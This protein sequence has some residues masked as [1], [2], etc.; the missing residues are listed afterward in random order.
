[1]VPS[2]QIHPFSN[3]NTPHASAT[4]T[5]TL[6]YPHAPPLALALHGR[7]RHG[8]SGTTVEVWTRSG[9]AV[10]RG[11]RRVVGTAGAH[12]RATR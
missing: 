8:D 6:A 9:R 5:T 12:H 3:N 10:A 11:R 4:E 7:H 2:P 1:M